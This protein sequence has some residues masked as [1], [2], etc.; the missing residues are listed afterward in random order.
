MLYSSRSGYAYYVFFLD[1]F[2]RKTWI[3]F[4]KNKDEVFSK[5]KDFKAL[6]EN[7]TK[8]R[9]KTF[10]S[11]NGRE[12]TSNEFKELS[13]YSGIKREFSTPYNPQKMGLYKGR[14]ELSWKLQELCFMIKIFLLVY[15]QRLPEQRCMYRTIL[16]TEYL[17]I[18]H[19]NKSFPARN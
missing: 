2:S 4:M 14:T 5:F 17:R 11:D 16:H 6:I 1:D 19:L 12:F 13:K 15:G 7:H 9:I 3:Y 8:K 10:R 18:R